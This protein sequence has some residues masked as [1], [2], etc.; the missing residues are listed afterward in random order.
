MNI[1]IIISG[2]IELFEQ[3]VSENY[4]NIINPLVHNGHTVNIFMSI[5]NNCDQDILLKSYQ[6]Y[7][8]VFDTE[9]FTDYTA[10]LIKDM[11]P[12]ENLIKLFAHTKENKVANTLYWMYKLKRAYKLVQE[13]ERINN[14]EHDLYIRLR[15]DV[16]CIDP[17]DMNQLN[18]LNDSSII[19]HVDHIVFKDNNV[20]GCG[21]GWIDDNLCI[22]KKRPFE[23]FCNTYDTIISLCLMAG[24]C[25]SHIVLKKQFEL[26]NIKTIKP[27]SPLVIYR[28]GDANNQILRFHY[29]G[30]CYY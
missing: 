24:S 1:A 28:N 29:F 23:I 2:R 7:V 16:T 13:Y 4:C 25:I 11:I 17:I 19:V 5:W 12:Y 9:I 8:K 14:I 21:E 10:G 6:P 27:N 18:M 30:H 3:S 26:N 15:P 20:Y 22:A